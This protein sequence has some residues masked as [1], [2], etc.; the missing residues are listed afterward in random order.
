MPTEALMGLEAYLSRQ[1][2]QLVME[3][4]LLRDYTTQDKNIKSL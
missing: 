1:G 3:R 2:E 4:F